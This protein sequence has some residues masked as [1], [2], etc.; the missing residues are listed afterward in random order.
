[1][2][3]SASYT[4]EAEIRALKKS[5]VPRSCYPRCRPLVLPFGAREG[6]KGGAEKGKEAEFPVRRE[7]AQKAD[8]GEQAGSV[9]RKEQRDFFYERLRQSKDG[10]SARQGCTQGW[11]KRRALEGQGK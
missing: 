7:S 10:D 1:M 4:A 3:P 6:T 9:S 8:E 5:E 11:V 2:A